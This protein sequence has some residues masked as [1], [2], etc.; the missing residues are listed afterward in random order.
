MN[1]E[2]KIIKIVDGQTPSS[3]SDLYDKLIALI[4]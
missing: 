2:Q 1:T 4:A 3:L